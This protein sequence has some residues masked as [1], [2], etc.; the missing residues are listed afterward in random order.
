M[1]SLVV[2]VSAALLTWCCSSRSSPPSAR[3]SA[4]WRPLI[5][6]EEDPGMKAAANAMIVP[7]AGGGVVSQRQGDA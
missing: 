3:C 2:A 4:S 6:P 7:E 1:V 5:S